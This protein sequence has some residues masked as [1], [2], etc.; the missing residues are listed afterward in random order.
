[1]TRRAVHYE[2]AFESYLR[3]RKRPY[4]AVDEARKTLL[5][6]GCW[7]HASGLKSFDFLLPAAIE[8]GGRSA[9]SLLVEIKGRRWAQSSRTSLG[10]SRGWFDPWVTREDVEALLAWEGLFGPGVVGAFV[11][12]LWC[13]AQ[14]P[15]GLFADVLQHRGRWYALQAIGVRSY[16]AHMRP[17]SPR[18]ATVTLSP[19]AAADLIGPLDAAAR[20]SAGGA[21]DAAAQGG[22]EAGTGPGG[23]PGGFQ[24]GFRGSEGRRW[25]P[26]WVSRSA[27]QRRPGSGVAGGTGGSGGG[28]GAAAWAGRGRPA[29]QGC[30]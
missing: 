10:T 9:A 3:T 11:F 17:R 25:R 26:A 15:D 13:P 1:M 8:S 7:A 18:W 2:A 21:R 5:P 28:C 23:F 12:V 16:R 14:P 19:E 27:G 24:A 29:L 22:P 30:G 6:P 4:V 20:T